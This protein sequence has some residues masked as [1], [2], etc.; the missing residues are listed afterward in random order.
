M[1]I[2]TGVQI[3]L[4]LIVTGVAAEIVKSTNKQTDAINTNNV[5]NALLIDE[6]KKFNDKEI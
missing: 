1:L 2:M 3:I 6:L 4:T 5:I